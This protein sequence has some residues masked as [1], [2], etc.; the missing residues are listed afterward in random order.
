MIF[1]FFPALPQPIP[2]QHHD[3][4]ADRVRADDA[5]VQHPTAPQL[6]HHDPLGLH[7][8]G[9]DGGL[10]ALERVHREHRPHRGAQIGQPAGKGNGLV[11]DGGLFG[12]GAGLRIDGELYDN[13]DDQ[14][15]RHLFSGQICDICVKIL[16]VR[17]QGSQQGS[18]S[19]LIISS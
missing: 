17:A 9:A 2:D 7:L 8:Y 18:R 13:R 3:D 14:V 16:C 19:T 1:L 11:H 15:R 12:G 10:C 5:A 6:S 4:R